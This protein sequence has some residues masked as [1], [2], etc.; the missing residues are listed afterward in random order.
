MLVISEH[1]GYEKTKNRF[2]LNE[3]NLKLCEDFDLNIPF[4]KCFN[5]N[6]ET[7]CFNFNKS[8]NGEFQFETGYYI[9]VDW[10]GNSGLS[11]YVQPKLNEEKKQVNYLKMLFEALK[12][13]ENLNHLNDLYTI[14][15]KAPL[16]PITQQQDLLAPL[17][18]IEF[19]QLLKNIVRKG[20]KK[21]YYKV[22][23]NLNS[24]VKGKILINATVKQ[25]HSHQKMLYNIC[26]FEE[27]GYNSIENSILKKALLFTQS[28]LNSFKIDKTLDLKELFNYVIPA[29]ES[30]NEDIDIR[31]VKNAKHNPLF[32]EYTHA[33]KLAKI[34]LKRYNYTISQTTEKI[35][36]TP[37]FWIDMPKLFELYVFKKLRESYPEKGEVKYHKKFHGLEPD[38]LLNTVVN[39]DSLKMII[40]AKYKPKY[41]DS[42][43]YLSD[44]RQVS[45]YAR[46]KSVYKEL[47]IGG[48]KQIIDCL[49][50]YSDQSLEDKPFIESLETKNEDGKYMHLFKVGIKL[51]E[52]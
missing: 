42:N 9:G 24:K 12:D 21:S 16:I 47:G 10:I 35:V 29:F 27:F 4:K 34:I 17:L 5:N 33:I 8:E 6:E 2:Y 20:L 14:D 26:T 36:K 51:P 44:A 45:G 19:L 41:K 23:E 28:A 25:N 52:L 43:I 13:S 18:L 50:V 3:D 15:F 30:V 1:F 39:G 46:L 40:D 32:K 7:I 49:I 37:P 22:T 48:S 31:V 38:Y 11:I